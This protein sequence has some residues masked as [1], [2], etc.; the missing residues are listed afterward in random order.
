MEKRE[1][2]EFRRQRGNHLDI[3]QKKA[4][5]NTPLVNE[6][7][8]APPSDT[9]PFGMYTGNPLDENDVPMQDADDL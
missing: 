3:V 9:D 7:V 6:L 8:N 2:L 4:V 5:E 1:K